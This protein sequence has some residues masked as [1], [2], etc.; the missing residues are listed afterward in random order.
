MKTSGAISTLPFPVEDAL[1]TLGSRI[2]LA[3][4]AR[5][6]TQPDLAARAGIGMSTLLAIERGASTV[7]IGFTLNTLWALGLEGTFAFVGAFGSDSEM[8]SLMAE[9]VPKRVRRKLK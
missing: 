3:R 2:S 1:K 4:R 5:G 8:T 7:Q 6:M 9:S